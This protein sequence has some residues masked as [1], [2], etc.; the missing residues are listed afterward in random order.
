MHIQDIMALSK[1]TVHSLEKVEL[2]PPVELIHTRSG[3]KVIVSA[4]KAGGNYGSAFVEKMGGK[5]WESWY[6]A[7]SLSAKQ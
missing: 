4:V 1:D 5:L 2:R 3:Q 6:S 7:E